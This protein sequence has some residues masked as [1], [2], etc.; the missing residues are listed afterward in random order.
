MAARA[1]VT[2]DSTPGGPDTPRATILFR[3]I[4]VFG[5]VTPRLSNP[6]GILIING[7]VRTINT[8]PV[9]TPSNDPLAHVGNRKHI[10]VPKLVSTRARLFVRADARTSLIT[11][12]TDPRTL[13]H[14]TRSGTAT[15]L[16]HKFADIHSVTKPIFRLGRT[17][18]TNAIIKLHV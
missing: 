12:A 16:V 9:S 1:D 2:R 14:R 4:R 5:N 8:R 15:V 7:A 13:F 3:G 18:S 17:V 11:T 6:T 10:L